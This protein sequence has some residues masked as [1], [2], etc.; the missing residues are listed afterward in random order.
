MTEDIA[1]HRPNIDSTLASPAN[2]FTGLPQRPESSVEK[3]RDVVFRDELLGGVFS[4]PF[5]TSPQ[6]AEFLTG[7]VHRL[8]GD[9]D[10]IKPFLRWMVAGRVNNPYLVLTNSDRPTGREAD[11]LGTLDPEGRLIE[12]PRQAVK[13]KAGEGVAFLKRMRSFPGGQQRAE[14]TLQI[15]RQGKI[16]GPNQD[17]QRVE[18]IRLLHELDSALGFSSVMFKGGRSQGTKEE[19]NY[20]F[21][22]NSSD[23]GRR[24]REDTG[25]IVDDLVRSEARDPEK[26]LID[27]EVLDE[28]EGIDRKVRI[29]R[30]VRFPAGTSRPRQGESQK[31]ID[32]DLAKEGLSAE[33]RE[34]YEV[35]AL[36]AHYLTDPLIRTALEATYRLDDPRVRV[37]N[38]EERG[39]SPG[40][41][42][43]IM[44]RIRDT[45]LLNDIP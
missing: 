19:K 22:Q 33:E 11:L 32:L 44:K 13:V 8:D 12:D 20:R 3:L 38:S 29:I 28:G 37:V 4:P 26:P 15:L 30:T 17:H 6:A 23:V 10:I 21:V 14:R 36:A 1:E 18:D 2:R 35:M 34:G 31:K 27:Y 24:Y 7:S 42:R 39:K 45:F 40:S 25:K 16:S 9:R 41:I 5:S 43:M